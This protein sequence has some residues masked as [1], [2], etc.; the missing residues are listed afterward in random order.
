MFAFFLYII[1]R[2]E[3]TF[4]KNASSLFLIVMMLFVVGFSLFDEIPFE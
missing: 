4:P 3:E 2:R 1:K